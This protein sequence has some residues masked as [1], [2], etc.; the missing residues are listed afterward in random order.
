MRRSRV[1]TRVLGVFA[2]EVDCG[3]ALEINSGWLL[4]RCS[5]ETVV[6]TRQQ[7][8]GFFWR[9]ASFHLLSP[10]SSKIVT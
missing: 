9:V 8:A 4:A 1:C 10:Q 5:V 2:A 6:T 3:Q 7:L